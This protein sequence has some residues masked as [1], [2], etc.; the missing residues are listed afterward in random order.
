MRAVTVLTPTPTAATTMIVLP[1]AGEGWINRLI[2]STPMPPTATNKM[3]ALSRA[4]K[5]VERRQP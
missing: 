1:A 2:A 3:T 4:A 5:I